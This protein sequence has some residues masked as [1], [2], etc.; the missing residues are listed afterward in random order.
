[1][2][3]LSHQFRSAFFFIH[4]NFWATKELYVDGIQRYAHKET[5]TEVCNIPILS[6]RCVI[7]VVCVTNEREENVV[8]QH[9]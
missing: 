3:Y 8:E 6:L 9:N 4:V 2:A 7:P 1:M 5:K